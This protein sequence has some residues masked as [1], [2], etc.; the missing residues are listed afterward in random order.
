MATNTQ[1]RP[2]WAPGEV[3]QQ[4]QQA[5]RRLFDFIYGESV[6][7]GPLAVSG[8]AAPNAATVRVPTVAAQQYGSGIGLLITLSRV[9]TWNVHGTAALNIVTDANIQFQLLLMT[10]GIPNAVPMATRGLGQL[11]GDGTIML[12]QNWTVT[13]LPTRVPIQYHL[14]VVKASGTGTSNVDPKHSSLSASWNGL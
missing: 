4:T 2:A 6:Q 7:Q 13:V 5:F 12:A 8:S 9:G 14:Q 3:S 11:S 10:V 1:W